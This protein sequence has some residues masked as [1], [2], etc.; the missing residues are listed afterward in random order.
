MLLGTLLVVFLAGTGPASA[1]AALRGTDPGDGSVVATAP[2]DLTLTFTESVGL[3]D[4]SVRVYDP[5]NHRVRLGT[6][7]HVPGSSDEIRVPLPASGL[8]KGT[9]TVAW[10]VVS[11]DSHPVSG[12]FTFS[13]GAPS[14][15]SAVVDTGPPENPATNA[16]QQTARYLAYL[17]GAVLIGAAV[18][19]AVCRPA[20]TSAL[21][22]LLRTAWW[23]LL[24]TT[25]ALLLLRAPY[26]A[27]TGPADAFDPDGL[28]RTLSGRPGI[29]LLV[30]LALLALTALLLVRLSRRPSPA[31]L[32]AGG[33]VAVGLAVTWAAAEHA[34]AGIQVPVA[35]ASS[36]LHLLATAVWLGG[37][38]AL[39]VTLYRTDSLSVAAVGRFSRVAFAS[40]TVLV[41][42][43]LYQ[44]W[45]GL[46][47]LEALTGTEYGRLL[48]IKL[49]VVGALL[50][51]AGFSRRFTI[52]WATAGARV[53]SPVE[54][55]VPAAIGAGSGA[56]GGDGGRSGTSEVEPERA[57]TGSGLP[58]GEPSD[59]GPERPDVASTPART[60]VGGGDDGLH[61][62]ALKRSVFAEVGIGLA[63]LIVTT[64]LTATLPGRAADEAAAASTVGQPRTVTETVAFDAGGGAYGKVQITL[65]PARVGDNS[66]QAVVFGPDNG[67]SI[68]PELRLSFSL[69]S[70]ELGPID[71]E[72]TDRGGYWATDSLNLPI[73]GSWT[74]KMTIRVSEVDQVS[75]VRTIRVER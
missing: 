10:R 1:H 31:L 7:A 40:V 52:G 15:T 9:Y 5:G 61:R 54:E 63:V 65:D 32:G 2:R 20:D 47:S 4:G 75:E 51:T 60:P 74:M 33:A 66:V 19:A 46:G 13:I 29:L 45:R 64:V 23:T 55:R 30:R 8:D 59:A 56:G 3:L 41:V 57:D 37:L 27:G 68:V 12:A 36:T 28:T 43:G 44:S 50:A 69:P 16:L 24:A 11:S 18:F 67:V 14:P 35:I 58:D 70:K 21:R 62:R 6:V 53:E 71:A 25:L 17:A 34:S 39:L 48:L 22:P 42:T 26:E 73:E 38:T 49:V 72:L